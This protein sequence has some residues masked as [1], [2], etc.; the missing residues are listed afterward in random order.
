MLGRRDSPVSASNIPLLRLEPILRSIAE[1]RN[2]GGIFFSTTVDDF[3]EVDGSVLVSV[4]KGDGSVAKYRA[5]YVV[6]CDG[7]KMSTQKLGIN[8]EGPAGIIDFVSTH[9]KADLSDYWDGKTP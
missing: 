6:A 1:E 9:F 2:P 7:G 3:E 8:M 5:Q 4:S